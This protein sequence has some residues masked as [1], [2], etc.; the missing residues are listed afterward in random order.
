VLVLHFKI[1]QAGATV[2]QLKNKLNC[3]RT[4]AFQVF[5]MLSQRDFVVICFFM[6]TYKKYY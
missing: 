5:L 6:S 1:V 3:D 4:A 2:P